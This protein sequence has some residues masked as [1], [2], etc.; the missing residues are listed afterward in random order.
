MNKTNGSSL[1]FCSLLSV[2]APFTRG[3]PACEDLN[4]FATDDDGDNEGCGKGGGG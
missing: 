4:T 3:P 1:K 2:G